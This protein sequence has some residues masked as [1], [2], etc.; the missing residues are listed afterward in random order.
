MI[1]ET[2]GYDDECQTATTRTNVRDNALLPTR[3]C[4]TRRHAVIWVA[5]AEFAVAVVA[6][7]LASG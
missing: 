5:A 2:D 4:A 3:L 1:R 7:D 6:L